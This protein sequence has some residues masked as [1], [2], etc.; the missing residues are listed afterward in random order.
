LER[1]HELFLADGAC[2]SLDWFQ[3]TC[4]G[5]R[6]IELT[7]WDVDTDEQV[8]KRSMM[9]T[10]PI[11]NR[12][13]PSQARTT[14][15][16]R[17]KRFD[18]HGMLVENTTVIVDNIPA[19]DSFYV[20]D[21]W[22]I[23]AS[24]SDSQQVILSTRF[25]ARFTK[26]ALFRG[27]I[28]KN[29]IKEATAWFSTYAEMV[30][31]K[32]QQPP[33]SS[34]VGEATNAEGSIKTSIV[35]QPV[36]P[37]GADSNL[38]VVIELLRRLSVSMDRALMVGACALVVLI[39]VLAYQLLLMQSTIDVMVNELASL[40]LEIATAEARHFPECAIRSDAV[41]EQ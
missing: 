7:G 38:S 39:A 18:D 14:R 10:H 23:Q 29:V 9:F 31:S 40:R 21:Y 22:V 5:D 19:V 37:P 27:L 6:D 4:I 41:C 1:F 16:Q 30:Q 8:L 15:H 36:A 33:Q 32:L 3:E 11:N 24:S 34:A 17:L 2:F 20:H 26:R 35:Q 28:E 25:A 13:G 12:L